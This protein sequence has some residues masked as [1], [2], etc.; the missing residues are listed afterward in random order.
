M[1]LNFNSIKIK[2]GLALLGLFLVCLFTVI[3]TFYFLGEQ[4]ENGTFINVAGRQRMLSQKMTK[5]ALACV[6]TKEA[7]W[8]QE[9]RKTADLFDKSLR[10]MRNGSPEMGLSPTISPKVIKEL[11]ALEGLW[12]PFH[13]NVQ[14][15]VSSQNVDDPAVKTAL[16]YL[17]EHN[18]AL[19]K[20]ANRLTQAYED[21]SKT[22]IAM[23]QRFQL[24]TLVLAVLLF[25]LGGWVVHRNVLDPLMRVIT[26]VKRIAD[27]DLT[28][29][30]KARGVGEL[31]DL[32]AAVNRMG[33]KLVKM[34]QEIK[35]DAYE[36]AKASADVRV[37]G[38]EVSDQAST[39]EGSAETVAA[40]ADVVNENIQLVSQATQ[41]LSTAA[42]EI[43]QSVAETARITNE[44]QDKAQMTNT[45]I[46]RLGESSDKIGNIIQVI[47][48]IAE[49]TNL[50]ALNATIEAARAGEAGKG[51]A[52]VANEVKELAKQTAEATQE[53]TSMIQTIQTDTKEA[54]AS[55]EEITAIVAQV[56]D[57]A[58]TIASAAEEQ[59][60]TVSEISNNVTDAAS[61]VQD[62]KARA[63]ETKSAAL[64][65]VT[66]ARKNLEASELL[67]SLSEKLKGLV[68]AFTT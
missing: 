20:Q 17:M 59:T 39:M 7:I 63:D 66:L 1:A 68:K 16:A 31:A 5:E 18:A 15:I 9:L 57:L 12:R 51:F 8:K 27:G 21:L 24:L 38:K 42:S 64:E 47:N 13:E 25:V 14:A 22:D 3:A 67:E 62:V 58:N 48:T 50:L 61:R 28:A 29:R 45:V 37:V 10:A 33:D 32:I 55:V 53:I 43:A 30:V 19:L 35:D 2:I 26:V 23:L 34:V 41:D 40:A 6:A 56:N 4:E 11:D 54:V 46:S 60:A 49:Q 44:A 52:V 36:V 65:T